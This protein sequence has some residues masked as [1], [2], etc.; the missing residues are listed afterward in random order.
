VDNNIQDIII[1][2]YRK[3]CCRVRI[4]ASKSLSLGFGK[5]QFHDN[6]NLNDKYYGEWE[7][8]TYSGSWRVVKNEKILLGSNDS[9]DDIIFLNKKISEIKFEEIVSISNLTT[10]DVR[11]EFNDGMIIDFISTISD[12]DEFFHIFCPNNVYIEFN[13]KGIWKVGKSDVPWKS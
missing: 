10:L 12:E 11:V 9:K 3:K 5:M 1:S 8:G 4:G 7:I 6:P 13:S 2:I